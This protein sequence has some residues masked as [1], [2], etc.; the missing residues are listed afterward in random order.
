MSIN[1]KDNFKNSL[2]YVPLLNFFLF[3]L[4]KNHKDEYKK[5][6][7]YGMILFILYFILSLTLNLFGLGLLNTL[8]FLMYIIISWILWYRAYNWDKID[9]E[10]LDEI[11]NKVKSNIK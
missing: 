7:K 2:A 3:F 11:E 6:L 1:Q 4:E 10:V 5:H 9:L 8:L